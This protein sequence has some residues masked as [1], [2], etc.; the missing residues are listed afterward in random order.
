MDRLSLQSE[1]TISTRN[2]HFCER[3]ICRTVLGNLL[4]QSS[5]YRVRAS[6]QIVHVV[7]HDTFRWLLLQ[8]FL[9]CIQIAYTRGRRRHIHTAYDLGM[10]LPSVASREQWT[11]CCRCRTAHL[12]SAHERLARAN[13]A[14]AKY[15]SFPRHSLP[16][17]RFGRHVTAVCLK[18][19]L[20][21]LALW[22]Q[23]QARGA[24]F[25]GRTARAS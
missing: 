22:G 8:S 2:R 24:S 14:N 11:Q 20:E 19:E 9:R 6:E 7:A 13:T 10:A 3:I 17:S 1:H 4:R 15:K 21:Q 12:R 25:T 5:R 16:L 23:V 18:C